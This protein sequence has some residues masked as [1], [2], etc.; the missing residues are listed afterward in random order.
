M[1]DAEK[2][3]PRVLIETMLTTGMNQ[4][5]T[6]EYFNVST[7][8]VR[9]LQ[10]RFKE[11]GFAAL[12][13][14]SKR[15]HTNPRA[16]DETVVQRIIELREELTR[17]GTDAGAQTIRWHLQQ[18][19]IDPLPAAS[20]IHRILSNNGYIT[21]QPQKRPRSSW[22]RFQ[23][24]QPNET[25]QMDYS[26]WIIAG[27]R[28]VAILTILDDHSRYVLYC[29][30]FTNATVGNVIDSFIQAAETNG[31]PQ[32]TLTDNG[33][34]FTTSTDRTNPS[35][36]GFEQLLLDLGIQQ[37]NGKPYHPQTQGKV[38]RFHYTL[39]L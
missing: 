14:Q 23:A 32:S 18:E 30:A 12:E 11:G 25:W 38:E 9:K 16:T 7:R 29:K 17:R 3:N 33:R 5:E 8:W 24:D 22:K 2:P 26:D 37:K 19:D 31:Y 10:K 27:H 4:T 20:T 15:P 13:P 36:N 35:R 21:P 39:K 6:A 28:R 1:Q 34:A